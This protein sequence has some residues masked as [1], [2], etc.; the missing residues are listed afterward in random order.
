M[1]CGTQLVGLRL[2]VKHSATKFRHIICVRSLGY[3]IHT[4][5]FHVPREISHQWSATECL[6]VGAHWHYM[7]VHSAGLYANIPAGVIFNNVVD[8]VNSDGFVLQT[9]VAKK[10]S[11][12]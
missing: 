10:R 1:A 3:K 2:D 6:R 7:A 4:Q 11:D 8:M 5:T 9:A 12:G